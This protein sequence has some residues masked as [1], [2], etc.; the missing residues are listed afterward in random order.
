LDS[1]YEFLKN[2]ENEKLF[3]K[4][5]TSAKR[6]LASKNH[7]V[8]DLRKSINYA[9]PYWLEIYKNYQPTNSEEFK[10]AILDDFDKASQLVFACNYAIDYYG[11]LLSCRYFR[12]NPD[13]FDEYLSKVTA[14]GFDIKNADETT[15]DGLLQ[16]YAL[17]VHSNFPDALEDINN[18]LYS[19]SIIASMLQDT[20][21]TPEE[22]ISKIS[23]YSKN[24][25]SARKFTQDR[26]KRYSKI[27]FYGEKEYLPEDEEILTE[28][29]SENLIYSI[30]KLIEQSQ[31]MGTYC[32]Y[33]QGQ[34][35]QFESFGIPNFV[36][37]N[38]NI[39]NLPNILSNYNVDDL[40]ALNSF[41]LNRYNKDLINY[42]KASFAVINLGLLDKIMSVQLP[43]DFHGYNSLN[44]VK[45]KTDIDKN[46]AILENL[47]KSMYLQITKNIPSKDLKSILLKYSLLY[48]PTS[49]FLDKMQEQIQTGNTENI[50]GFS[51]N[52]NEEFVRFSYEP[53]ADKTYRLYG[54]IYESYFQNL[55]PNTESDLKKDILLFAPL[56]CPEHTSYNQK[57]SA[58]QD[59]STNFERLTNAGIVIEKDKKGD[60]RTQ[61][62]VLICLDTPFCAP[63]SEHI[64]FKN[65]KDFYINY[66]GQSKI[67][68]YDGDED[69]KDSSGKHISSKIVLPMM[70]K[71][72]E[73]LKQACINKSYPPEVK[74]TI[75]HLY[76]LAN[77]NRF[78]ESLANKSN[79]KKK[80]RTPRR[81]L[82]L[83]DGKIYV[84]DENNQFVL[85]DEQETSDKMN[86]LINDSNKKGPVY[87]N[88]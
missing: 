81:Y 74:N 45:I 63:I 1:T 29:I 4:R 61:N 6:F 87:D 34:Q 80:S 79:S 8:P 53:L 62:K 58:L 51:K 2:T 44:D 30:K 36:C 42:A 52:D 75:E 25:Y 18:Y 19:D 76:F 70:S 16:A 14:N 54:P 26:I 85:S 71:Q 66:T 43:K 86:K 57:V 13:K 9:I 59:L 22:C 40:F 24:E 32:R 41:W 28:N 73:L 77:N 23:A 21:L 33:I 84:K 72:V 35:E 10:A 11:E 47:E 39:A 65:L 82:D 15:L 50:K 17:S 3:Q 31:K 78:P 83:S 5:L 88:R 55:L 56:Y 64:H 69:F 7:I 38:I 67:A 68:I 27:V 46:T 12:K 37:K 48:Y 20:R 60:Y 49:H